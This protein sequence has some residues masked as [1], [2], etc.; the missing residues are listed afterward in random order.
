MLEPYASK[1]ACTVLRGGGEGNLTSLPDYGMTELA[2]LGAWMQAAQ[3]AYFRDR[4]PANLDAARALERQ[5]D[6]VMK[7]CQA[8][9]PTLFGEIWLEPG[10]KPLPA[11]LS[12]VNAY[13][14]AI[15]VRDN[16]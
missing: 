13:E 9:Q 11:E 14:H 15:A 6:R 1:G 4:T 2:D 12:N 3:R 16:G 7:E 10:E 5:V 8:A